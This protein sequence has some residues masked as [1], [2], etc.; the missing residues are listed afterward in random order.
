MMRHSLS[1]ELIERLIAVVESRR[2]HSI[3]LSVETAKI[4]LSTR[5]SAMIDLT[6]IERDFVVE[7]NRD[8]LRA[9]IDDRLGA[10]ARTLDD[11]LAA[12]GLTGERIDAVFLTGRLDGDPG[13]ARGCDGPNAAGDDRRGRFIRRRRPGVRLGRAAKIRIVSGLIV[14][15]DLPPAKFAAP[16]R[17]YFV[18]ILVLPLDSLVNARY[19]HITIKTREALARRGLLFLR[20]TARMGRPPPDAGR[21]APFGVAPSRRLRGG[22]SHGA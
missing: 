9:A 1:P 20:F 18:A 4:G 11:T 7:A 21:A 5:P 10:L 17:H 3:A 16:A 8:I 12:A 6:D 15:T 2:G 22:A 14:A 19:R 13:G